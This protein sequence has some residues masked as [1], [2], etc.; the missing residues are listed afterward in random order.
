MVLNN[1]KE[2]KMNQT[3]SGP[4]KSRITAALLAFFL[5]I[6]GVHKF[7]LGY[8]TTGI[9]QVPSELINGG[10]QKDNNNIVVDSG[11][12]VPRGSA[13][14]HVGFD[15]TP[16]TALNLCYKLEAVSYTHLTLPTKRIV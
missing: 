8:S 16:L 13:I 5:G 3:S 9:I 6:F 15:P 7:Y 10:G 1:E 11:G 2:N 12:F 14:P 4:E